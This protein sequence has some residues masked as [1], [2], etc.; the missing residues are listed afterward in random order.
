MIKT[1]LQPQ[2]TQN[3]PYVVDNYPYGYTMR[4]RM[5][6]WIETTNRG[7]R[8]VRQSLNPKTGKWNKPK[9][10]TY[11][12]IMLAGLNEENHVKFTG[13]SMYSSDEA[14]KFQEK[15]QEYFND[16]QRKEMINI[17]KMLE[18]YDKVEYTI[19]ARKFMNKITGEI[20]ESVPLFEMNN[21]IE[22]DDDGKPVDREAEDKKQDEMRS[23]INRSAVSNASKATSVESAINTFKRVK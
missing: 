17:L 14:K 4:T 7:Q 9:K 3:D 19:R 16:Y 10:S 21:Y 18:V 15:Y 22:V 6:Y 20:T 11:C 2:P 12:Q 8:F 5:R 13:I 23:L 1:V